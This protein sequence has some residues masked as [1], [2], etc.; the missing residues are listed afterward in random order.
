MANASQTIPH[1]IDD[2]MR[3]SYVAYAMSVIVGR[4][5]PDVRDGLK[6]VH[7]RVLY[8]MHEQGIRAGTSYKKSARVVGDVLGKYHPHGDSAVYDALVRMAQDF[9]LRYPL[10][11]GQ[12]NFGSVDGDP[13]AAMRY[14]E[15]RLARISSDL[16]ADIDKETVD[17]RPNYDDSELE[18]SV[19]PSRVPNLLVNGSAGIAVGMA[20]NIPPHN[21]REIVD[22]TVRVIRRPG[23]SVDELM[24]D[25]PAEGWLGV[26]GPDFPTAGFIYGTAGIRQALQTGRGRVV[27]RARASVEPMGGRGDREMI[28]VTEIPYQVNKAELL[29]KIAELVREKKIE[30]ISDLRDES[31]RDGMRVVVEL[32]RDVPGQIVLNQLYQ[33]TALQSTFGVNCLAIV[34]GQPQVLNL[35]QALQ[36]FVAHRREVVTR[37]T[38]FDL[39]KAKEQRELVEGLGM[40]T[41]EVDLVVRTIRESKDQEEARTRLMQLPLR[42]LEDFVRRAGRSDAEIAAAKARGDYFLS[43][44]QAKAI[45]EMRLARLTGLEREKLS[46][47]YG[48][49]CDLIGYLESILSSE[50]KLL[51]VIVDELKEVREK[52]GDD[53]RTEI[54]AAEGDISMEDLIANEPMAVTVT[55]GGYVKRVPL[56]EYRAQGRGGKGTRATDLRDE[57][58]VTSLFVANAHSN[59]LFLTTGGK[60]FTKKVYEVPQSSRQARG[61]HVSNLIGLEKGDSVAAIVPVAEFADDAYLLTCT[62]GGTVKRTALSAYGNIRQTGIIGVHIEEGDHLLGARLVREDE[63]VLLGTAA[64]M[65][66][67]FDVAD[68]RATGRGTMGVL[69]IGLRESSEAKDGVDD[70]VISMDVIDAEAASLLRLDRDARA[71]ETEVRIGER[72]Q[73]LAMSANGYGKRTPITEWKIQNRGG[74]GLKAI[75]TSARNGALVALR[76]VRPEDQVMVITDGGQILRTS[77]AQIREISRNTQGVRIIRVSDEERVVDVEPVAEPEEAFAAEEGAGGDAGEGSEPAIERGAEAGLSAGEEGPPDA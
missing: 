32:K 35:K 59:L 64:G 10:I 37:R 5:I 71:P 15:C 6:P 2:E 27:M 58:F 47:E 30:G 50:A 74:L 24:C 70:R 34:Q 56:T 75:E 69:G 45:L 48:Q 44:R 13:A 1:S 60:A 68:V 51:D 39:R 12:G 62:R 26:K 55:H 28:V 14:T 19:L 63:A 43:E 49:L 76:A 38:R 46:Q 21:L 41:T 3:S 67:C 40:A 9:A 11:D 8:S 22:A 25:D 65:S 77:V 54:V 17:W 16:L 18:P 31:D 36:Y 20:T 4:A 73:V 66:I 53:R 52:F 61:R 72:L 42:G 57:D 23:V 33:Q 29:K 7:R